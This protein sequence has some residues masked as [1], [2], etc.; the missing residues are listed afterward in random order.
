MKSLTKIIHAR[1]HTGLLLI[2]VGS[3]SHNNTAG[4][5]L[6]LIH[7]LFDLFGR[8]YPIHNRHFK[9]HKYHLVDAA[10]FRIRFGFDGFQAIFAIH[11]LITFDFKLAFQSL[12]IRLCIVLRR[13]IHQND[14][15]IQTSSF[16]MSPFYDISRAI[17]PFLDSIAISLFIQP[18]SQLLG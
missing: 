1:N 2:N 18:S 16:S 13:V 15:I 10:A 17:W 3:V 6:T 11:S 7:F 14:T 12:N 4:R 9:I 5:Q 8:L